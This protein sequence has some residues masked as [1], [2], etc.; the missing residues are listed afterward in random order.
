MNKVL[1][2]APTTD[3][4]NYCLMD[5]YKN[6]LNFKHPNFEVFLSDNSK[7]KKNSEYLR[8]LG[9]SSD[10]VKPSKLGII[11]TMAKSHNQCREYAIKYNYEWMLHLE[12]DV[13]PPEDIIERLLSHKKSVCGA[14]YHIQHGL[15]RTLLVQQEFEYSKG[16]GRWQVRTRD[17]NS[18]AL[19]M[20]GSLK[21]VYNIGLGCLLIH[22]NVF[23][24]FHFRS[25]KG[26]DLHPDSFFAKDLFEQRIPIYVD[27]SII[28]EHRNSDWGTYGIDYK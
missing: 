26:M 3:S 28:C 14:T 17:A 8:T 19:F 20:D 7:T 25:I 22:K 12:T 23:K 2:A 10:W 5:W 18:A 27:T 15:D 16:D 9:I 13:F 6:V 11:N 21:R 24:N 1:I 4:K